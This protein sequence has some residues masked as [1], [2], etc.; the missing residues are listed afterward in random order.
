[1]C[2]CVCVWGGGGGGCMCMCVCV[3][4]CL[5]AGVYPISIK[6]LLPSVILLIQSANP[7]STINN[8]VLTFATYMGIV[9]LYSRKLNLTYLVALCTSTNFFCQ[10]FTSALTV[11]SWCR[12]SQVAISVADVWYPPTRPTPIKMNS[13]LINI[14]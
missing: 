4:T 5:H 11:W 6:M 13:H 8:T 9:T 2:V 12:W 1:M 3:R 7:G 14:P 10:S